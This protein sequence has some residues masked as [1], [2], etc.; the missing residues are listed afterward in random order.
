MREAASLSP[1]NPKVKSA[2]EGIQ[3]Q[4]GHH[5]LGK[6]CSRFAHE[7]DE[8]AGI[9]TVQYLNRSAE[10]PANVARECMDL[11]LD[12]HSDKN[13]VIRDDILAGLLRES[14][15]AKAALA[16]RLQG[17][18]GGSGT[19]V[20]FEQT[21][22]IGNGAANGIVTV[23]LDPS[24]WSTEAA[25]EA[26]EQDVFQ[27]FLAKLLEVGCDQD[28]RALKGISR[29]LAADAPHL[30]TLMDEVTVDM[31]LSTL[32]YRNTP[33]IRS[34]GTLSIA[35]YLEASKSEGQ[36]ALTKYVTSRVA[37]QKN[38][39]LVLAFSAAAAVF[40][41]APAMASSLFLV[42]GFVPSLPA[43]LEKKTK[44]EKVEHAAFEMLSAACIDSAC[45]EAIGKHCTFWLRQTMEAGKGERSGQAAVILAKLSGSSVQSD[46][47]KNSGMKDADELVL[48][49]Q[50]MLVGNSTIE[51]QGSIE[52]LAYASVQ[53]MVKA[54]LAKDK[55][56]L[57]VLLED[58][59]EST[60]GSPIA[61]GCLTVIN[62]MTR[63]PPNLSEEQKRMTQL[64][65]YANATAN[66]SNNLAQ[67]DPVDQE[68]AVTARCRAVLDAGCVP[69][70][71]RIGRLLSPA[72]IALV[73]NIVL[74]LSWP[75]AHR[76]IIAQQGGLK[77]LLQLHTKITG[78]DAESA[79]VRH[80][81]AHALARILTSVD[82]K[83]VFPRSGTPSASSAVRPLMSLLTE[84]P[85]VATEGPRDLL[86]TFEALLALANM[87]VDTSEDASGGCSDLI[88]RLV[89]P[90]L[91][92]LI[93]HENV[94]I[95]RAATQLVPNLVQ[96]PAGVALFADGSDTAARRLHILLALSG[97]EDLETRKAAGGALAVLSGYEASVES[98]LRQERGMELLIA[99]LGDTDD[100]V[101]YRGLY[102]VA[103]ALMTVG[104]IAKAAKTE[105]R[106]LGLEDKLEIIIETSKMPQN[107]EMAATAMNAL[108]ERR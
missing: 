15:A 68:K 78:T 107:S 44:S 17:S 43:L 88:A 57:E 108:N 92:D 12:D 81:R 3:K 65:A 51:K 52:G 18:N 14:P 71:V 30:H 94:R 80:I 98:M 22:N 59:R 103:G 47:D 100:D 104:D 75:Q 67:P 55:P 73:F 50:K 86:P 72:S 89:H 7:H 1:D 40:P 90:A 42:E 82:P 20:A 19:T 39:D 41:V 70:L 60:E 83:L 93:L 84:D 23:V 16:R 95:R 97:S 31:I 27:L 58:L 61:F 2:L 79:R 33:E 5:A 62:N 48:R 13:V 76:G 63:Y 32:D 99:M 85:L 24:A 37:N 46:S 8:E 4:D 74:S 69:T 25:R 96:H 35:K 106:E 36:S 26:C 45:R 6:L 38:E 9:K 21:Y 77:L 49:L 101:V 102:A 34:Q 11:M 66:A 53:P 64:K 28:S 56:F 54:Q 105:L 29:L 10:V 91:D 87:L